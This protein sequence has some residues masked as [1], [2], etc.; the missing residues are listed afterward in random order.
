MLNVIIEKA[1]NTAEQ[2]IWV[3]HHPSHVSSH[4]NL[5]SFLK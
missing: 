3:E 5:G 1:R 2:R 4:W